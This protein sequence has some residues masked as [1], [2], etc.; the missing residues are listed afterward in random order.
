MIRVRWFLL[1]VVSFAA[2]ALLAAALVLLNAHGF[3]AREQPTLVE[4]V[5]ARRSRSAALPSDARAHTN[6]I[7]NTPQML[8]EA[9]AHWADHCAICHANDGSGD[10]QLGKHN[11]PPAPDMRLP[12]TQQ[13]SDGELFYII[14]NGI[15]LT[16]MPAWGFG[17]GSGLTGFVEAR[18]FHSS[19][20]AVDG[21]GKEGN[22]EAE[23]EEPRRAERGRRR[24]K[25]SKGRR[26]S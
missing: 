5:V 9:R 15:R 16:A 14:Q 1:G 23:P 11:Y 3:S 24:G 18:A 19:L 25:V 26:Y 13:M 10:T 20:A 21:C 4:G 6:P 8:A 22:G 12:V 17:Q 7:P 2:I